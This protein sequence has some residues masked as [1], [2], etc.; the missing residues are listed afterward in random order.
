M[1]AK[2]QKVRDETKFDEFADLD[3]EID[4]A[5]A[6]MLSGVE[7]DA[8]E[9]QRL[10]IVG[11]LVG[12][13]FAPARVQAALLDMAAPSV[14]RALAVL[15]DETKQPA[16]KKRR[17]HSA[18]QEKRASKSVFRCCESLCYGQV[19]SARAW[20]EDHAMARGWVLSSSEG[21]H[22][23]RVGQ[24]VRGR[25][26]GRARKEDM[27]GDATEREV[28]QIAT[29]DGT[30]GFVFG[31][32]L[33]LLDS[34]DELEAVV[35]ECG[36]IC[37][38]IRGAA[39]QLRGVAEGM[40][41]LTARSQEGGVAVMIYRRG[42][43]AYGRRWVA[44]DEVCAATAGVAQDAGCLLSTRTSTRV[45]RD[46]QAVTDS[47]VVAQLRAP[48]RLLNQWAREDK[49][50]RGQARGKRQT[51]HVF[52]L[53]LWREATHG[54]CHSNGTLRGLMKCVVAV[55][56]RLRWLAPCVGGGAAIEVALH[57]MGLALELERLCDAADQMR[58]AS[59]VLEE[60]DAAPAIV[61]GERADGLQ[62]MTLPFAAALVVI[63]KCGPPELAALDC[64]STGM[65]ASVGQA[66]REIWPS[67]ARPP[68]GKSWVWAARH[69]HWRSGPPFSTALTIRVKDQTGEETYFKITKV[70]RMVRTGGLRIT[71]PFHSQ[72]PAC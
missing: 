68:R 24:L 15:L 26:N 29:P 32:A 7:S 53:K 66:I 27:Y 44:G 17:L 54:L 14:E 56:C 40:R 6:A 25:H 36:R 60:S 4:A 70:T 58:R 34:E 43:D 71:Q 61:A 52:M 50:L 38:S 46:D 5:A 12:M 63:A 33:E 3:V 8:A 41:L 49:L 48:V 64:V 67:V 1:A 31:D 39:S 59:A 9:R 45:R 37:S 69:H 18:S 11:S 23:L 21:Q 2:R 28:V 30:P 55:K 57:P 62:M 42:A 35:E 10:R 51:E 13:G 16:S 22:R 19:Y 72:C 65:S 47:C 20:V